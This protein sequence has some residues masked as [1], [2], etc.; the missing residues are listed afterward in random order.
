[1]LIKLASYREGKTLD[2]LARFITDYGQKNIYLA[3]DVL[4]TRK[5]D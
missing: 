1:M 2:E 5:K 3:Q 4:K